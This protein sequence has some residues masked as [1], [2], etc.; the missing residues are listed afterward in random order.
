[1]TNSPRV[2]VAD[3]EKVVRDSFRRV[4]TA[5]GYAVETV[6]DGGAALKKAQEEAFD[7]VFLDLK[8]PGV[9]GLEVARSLRKAYPAQQ[10]VIVTGYGSANSA[11][12]AARLGICDF[13]SKP[14]EPETIQALARAALSRRRSFLAYEPQGEVSH[15]LWEEEPVQKATPAPQATRPQAAPAPRPTPAPPVEVLISEPAFEGSLS[16][17][18][19][20]R[21]L[22]IPFLGLLYLLLF[23]VIGAVLL[24]YALG[25]AAVAFFS[26]AD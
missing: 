13:V 8:M 14:V 11:L 20:L 4:L 26:S 1:M 16:F 23:P 15:V 17:G 3:D 22:A 19:V 5:D 25:K 9:D 10:I 12:D 7:I 18:E 6:N 2:L 21:L 24:L